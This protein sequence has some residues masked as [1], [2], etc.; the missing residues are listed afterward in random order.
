MKVDS[1]FSY[2]KINVWESTQL[3]NTKI[4]NAK[5]IKTRWEQNIND[6]RFGF[7]GATFAI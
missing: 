6:F 4:D 5:C 2:Y 3:K 7:F 1:C